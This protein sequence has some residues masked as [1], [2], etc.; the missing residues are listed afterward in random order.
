MNGLQSA[1]DAAGAGSASVATLWWWMFALGVV[2]F[3]GVAA[4]LAVAMFR[5]RPDDD[6]VPGHFP[7]NVPLGFRIDVRDEV[8]ARRAVG[9]A[10]AATVVVLLGTFMLSL[11]ASRS[12]AAL[13]SEGA[14]EIEVTGVQWWWDVRYMDSLPGRVVRTANELHLPTGRTVRL[15]LASRDVIHSF[16]VPNLHGKMDLI[17]GRTNE[18]WIRADRPGTYR[19]QCAEFCGLQHAKMALVVVVHP[20][21]E[22]ER[23]LDEMRRPAIAPAD[24]LAA[25]GAR[26]FLRLPCASCHAIRGTEARGQAG[27][28][29]TH[30]AR[31]R[32]IAAGER[33]N[34]RAN[35]G[36]WLAAPQLVKPGNH[37][38]HV[39]LE[40]NDLQALVVYLTGLQ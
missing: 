28:D 29:L 31:R 32:T 5:R 3:I 12:A 21:D 10:I 2:V 35:L 25:A 4:A 26:A 37:M 20:P 14:P 16:W 39:S 13:V 40:A 30:F 36:G 23:W 9:V 18:L 33:A 38:P 1:L 22:Y 17:P 8:R 24:S 15:R 7:A 34:T 6:A 11:I 27:P 19:G